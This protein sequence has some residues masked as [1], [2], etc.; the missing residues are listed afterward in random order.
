MNICQ[1]IM[2]MDTEI[3]IDQI[4]KDAFDLIFWKDREY[5][6]LGCNLTF[7]KMAGFNSPHELIGKTDYDT[8]WKDFA[9]KFRSDDKK[10]L[11]GESF[12]S[13]EKNITANHQTRIIYVKKKPI[14][15]DDE[16]IGIIGYGKILSEYSSEVFEE[17]SY[18]ASDF[19]INTVVINNRLISTHFFSLSKPESEALYFLIRGFSSGKTA[20]IL[21]KSP[22]TIEQNI[23]SMKQ[24][25]GVNS[26]QLMINKAIF[27]GYTSIIPKTLYDKLK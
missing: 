8:C 18:S 15:K 1:N 26:K 20:E 19:P 25:M 24:K 3:L 4:I 12:E 2:L 21:S 13:I 9:D 6:F 27:Y 22:R 16:Y 17:K 7:A 5:Q 10:V 23:E 11:S 14:I